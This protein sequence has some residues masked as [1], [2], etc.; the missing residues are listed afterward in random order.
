MTTELT[1]S[2]PAVS[3]GHCRAAIADEVERVA[4]V[5]SV[6]VDLDRRLVTVRGEGVDDAAVRGAIDE[7]GYDVEP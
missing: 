2:V 5:E 4:G 1:Y 3:C 7:A 6:D